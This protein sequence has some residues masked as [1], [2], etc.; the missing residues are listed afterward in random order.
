M[1]K[2]E[3][4]NLI[5]SFKLHNKNY[6]SNTPNKNSHDATV[7]GISNL[8]QKKLSKLTLQDCLR[9]YEHKIQDDIYKIK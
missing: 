2:E 8:N 7:N 9:H 5:Q 1:R 4:D 6:V 3:I